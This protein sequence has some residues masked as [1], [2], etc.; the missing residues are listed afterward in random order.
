MCFESQAAGVEGIYDQHTYYDER[1]L[2][3]E[4]GATF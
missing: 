2:H 3:L 4:N 1:R